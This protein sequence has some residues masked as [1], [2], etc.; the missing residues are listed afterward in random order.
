MDKEGSSNAQRVSPNNG[1]VKEADFIPS[2]KR[3]ELV[4]NIEAE[5][6]CAVCSDRLNDPKVL[7]CL[8]TF[9]RR[10]VEGL[11][12]EQSSEDDS[13]KVLCSLCREE[14]VLPAKGGVSELPTSPT[15]S[16]LV[17]LLE[18]LKAE[19]P[20]HKE[21]LTCESGRDSNPAV[22]RCLDCEGYLCDPCLELHKMQVSS[23]NHANV[24]LK[25]IKESGGKCLFR[26]K[27]CP[28]HKKELNKYCF[29]CSELMC[30]ECITT[31]HSHETESISN[32]RVELNKFLDST[33]HLVRES[34]ESKD[35]LEKSMEKHKANVT[36]IHGKVD[37]T[38]EGLIELLKKRQVEIHNE[39]DTH[40][41][42][43]GEKISADV[44]NSR[45][46]LEHLTNGMSFV[47]RLLQSAG[48]SGLAAVAQQTLEQC[49][50]LEAIEIDKELPKVS[51]WV[52]DAADKGRD[53]VAGLKV[54]VKLPLR[55][56]ETQK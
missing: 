51:D 18:V 30:E 4:K 42:E 46:T 26:E 21:A 2:T 43:E 22:V 28:A 52:F 40:A 53:D 16:V 17:R 27:Y 9:C 24:T 10:C 11:V 50:K 48:D 56:V 31:H 12:L 8:H 45:L 6:T 14:H 13:R 54:K 41:K 29:T 3:D 1:A 49:N 38:I 35:T 36:A 7:P 33:K 15:F 19:P 32:I 55:E 34:K 44:E 23:R 25:E 5:L 37:T 20:G 47:D 39:I